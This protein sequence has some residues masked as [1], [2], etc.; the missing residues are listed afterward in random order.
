[1]IQALKN[2]I[3]D[4]NVIRVYLTTLG[5][6]TAYGMAISVIAVFLDARGYKETAIGSLAAWFAA[7]I[8]VTAV[9]SGYLVGRFSAKVVLVTALFTYA[10]TVALFPFAPSYGAIAALRFF[11][12]AASVCVWVASETILLAR[13]KRAIKAFITSIY[14][15]SIA[16]GYGAGSGIAY[17]AADVLPNERIFLVAGGLTIATAFFVLFKLDRSSDTHHEEA[18]ESGSAHA[19]QRA[20]FGALVGR[21]KASCFATFAYGYFQSSVVLFLPLFMVAEKGIEPKSTRLITLFF[22]VGMLLATN[23]AGRIGDRHG[24]LLVMRLLAI[25]GATMIASFVWLNGL[26]AMALAVFVAG[27]SLASI[28]PLSLAL[29]GL[30][31]REYSRAT[32]IYNAFYAA[33]MLL[34]PPISSQIFH[35]HGG[36]PMLYHLAAIWVA[37]VV[38]AQVYRRDDPAAAGN[39]VTASALATTDQV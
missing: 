30:Q 15:M 22:A 16:V 35:L 34:G 37:F 39:A 6:G 13:A 27:A 1:M 5:L 2:K 9:A 8:M 3:N 36:G 25:V 29:Q 24:H 26:P 4:P 11:D 28:S 38:F 19:G 12:G 17:L 21:I 18:H 31:T 20:T 10:T 23:F 7:G 14:A 32:G 33:G